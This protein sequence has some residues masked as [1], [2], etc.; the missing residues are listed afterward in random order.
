MCPHGEISP[1]LESMIARL[2][3]NSVA[4]CT[5]KLRVQDMAGTNGRCQDICQ[6]SRMVLF[7]FCWRLLLP[8][9]MMPSPFQT[10]HQHLGRH[11]AVFHPRARSGHRGTPPM[12]EEAKPT[13][14]DL[15][16]LAEPARGASLSRSPESHGQG[17]TASGP[18]APCLSDWG[19]P[20][21]A[22]SNMTMAKHRI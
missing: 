1:S 22:T 5:P 16:D 18:H 19:R 10:N 2:F 15:P 21:P 11:R 12:Q 20:V 3:R 8:V 4:R 14:D 9:S 6:T 13:F 7:P 17:P